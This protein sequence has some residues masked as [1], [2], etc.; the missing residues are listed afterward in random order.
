MPLDVNFF[1]T[2]KKAIEMSEFGA[3][4]SFFPSFLVLSF[5]PSLPFSLQQGRKEIIDVLSLLT[6]D[7]THLCNSK[8][9]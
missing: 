2:Y 6:G 4:I 3:D 8:E 5:L 9:Y 1:S 7:E